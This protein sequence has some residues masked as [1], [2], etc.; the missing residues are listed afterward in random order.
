MTRNSPMNS[1]SQPVLDVSSALQEVLVEAAQQAALSSRWQQRNTKLSG[2]VF[3]QALVFGWLANTQA[4][5]AELAQAAG[6]AGVLISPQGIEQRLNEAATVLLQQVLEAAVAQALAAKP[7]A[8]PLLRRFAGVYVLDSSIINLPAGLAEQWPGNGAGHGTGTAA[9]KLQVRFDLCQ[10]RLEG[11]L[12]RAGRVHD[13]CA[14]RGHG[15]LPAGALHVADLGY[16][17]LAVFAALEAAQAFYL[18]RVK[19]NTLFGDESGQQALLSQWVQ[20]AT[21]QGQEHAGVLE[22]EL[23]MG[24]QAALPCR[25]LAVRAPATVVAQ[26]KAQLQR[27]AQRKQQ[28]VS[29]ERL[30]L[31]EWTVLVT[32]VPA[33]QLSVAE[34]LVLYR[35]RWQIERLFRLWKE[36]GQADS[37][38]SGKPWAILCEVYAKLLGC[39]IQHW[40]L[41]VGAWADPARSWHK[42]AQVVHKQAWHLLCSL[43]HD[44]LLYQA[45]SDVVRCMRCGCRLDKR[46]QAPA[47]FQLLLD[48][49]AGALN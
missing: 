1:I 3:V 44:K 37:W 6:C 12:L 42:A 41:L 29:E 14:A 21:A 8:V 34:A 13:A 32:N 35:A 5:R 31:V 16:F 27:T 28:A 23:R 10:G 9:L 38:R 43:R 39:V 15:V 24:A 19:A 4:S 25:V 22:L 48:G 11:P 46:K 47:T 17:D 40:L 33:A 20:Q 45:L 18:S 30:A 2:P 7:V 36:V 26:R 49:S